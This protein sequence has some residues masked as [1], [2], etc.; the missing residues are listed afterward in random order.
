ML[1]LDFPT[2]TLKISTNFEQIEACIGIQPVEIYKG[3]DDFIALVAGENDVQNLKPDF[4][5]ISKLQSR[6]L[7]VTAKGNTVDFVSRVFAPQCG[8]DEDPVTGSAHTSL[9]PLW[10]EKLG[11]TEMIAYQLSKRGGKLICEYKGD[12]CLIGGL[13]KLY[14][15]GELTTE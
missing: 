3:K 11:K 13:A 7:I 15:T 12:R 2:D 1:F 4:K 14:L 8:I 5:E 10:S 6:G 9:I